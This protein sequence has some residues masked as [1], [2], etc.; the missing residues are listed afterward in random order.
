MKEDTICLTLVR[1]DFGWSLPDDSS[2]HLG[3]DAIMMEAANSIEK[4]EDEQS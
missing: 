1:T 3:T 2:K 4:A